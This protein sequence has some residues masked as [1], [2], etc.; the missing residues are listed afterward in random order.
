MDGRLGW[1]FDIGRPLMGGVQAVDDGFAVAALAGTL[2]RLDRS[3][4]RPWT[5]AARPADHRTGT[6]R[7]LDDQGHPALLLG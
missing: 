4:G 6:F 1:R 2:Y 7:V 3:G 5:R